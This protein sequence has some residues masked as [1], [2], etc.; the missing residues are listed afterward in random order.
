[1][2]CGRE[3]RKSVIIL[4]SKPKRKKGILSVDGAAKGG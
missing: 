2:D 4:K 1:M 3:K